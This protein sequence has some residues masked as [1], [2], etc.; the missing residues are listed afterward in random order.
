ML[1]R[2]IQRTNEILIRLCR[3]R[4]DH[5][6]RHDEAERMNRI[7]WIRAKHDIAGRRDRL[8]HIGEAFLGTKRRNDLCIRVELHTKT[9]RIILCLR[10]AKT[11]DALRRRISMRARVLNSFAKLVDDVLWRRQIRITHSEINDV[12][13]SRSRRCL[14]A[15]YLFKDIRWQATDFMKFFRHDPV[16]EG[17]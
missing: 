6:T 8:R 13:S 17:S 1:D 14:Q 15:I 4:T 9:T 16:P 5:T 2:T 12:G 11:G 3:N 7:G 10:T